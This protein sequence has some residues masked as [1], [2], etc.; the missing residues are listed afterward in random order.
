ME[1]DILFDILNSLKIDDVRHIKI[2]YYD[3]NYLK[4]FEYHQIE[5]GGN[6]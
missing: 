4:E 3:N 1:K 6:K 5:K 2:E